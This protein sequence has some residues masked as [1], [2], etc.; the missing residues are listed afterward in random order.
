MDIQMS[1]RL[2]TS[3]K[4]PVGGRRVGSIIEGII[5]AFKRHPL[6]DNNMLEM[7]CDLDV[8]MSDNTMDGILNVRLQQYTRRGMDYGYLAVREICAELECQGWRVIEYGRYMAN[9]ST[10]IELVTTA[11]GVSPTYRL[12]ISI[13]D[14]QPVAA[15][16]LAEQ[17]LARGGHWEVNYAESVLELQTIH[18]LFLWYRR[19]QYRETANDKGAPTSLE[20]MGD[21]IPT[22]PHNDVQNVRDINLTED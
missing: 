17:A 15:G 2:Q 21:I 10:K 14:V 11:G 4:Y 3:L 19:T 13:A 5:Y 18:E 6:Q 8:G 20:P 12:D 7:F 22:R 1:P 16:S 9:E